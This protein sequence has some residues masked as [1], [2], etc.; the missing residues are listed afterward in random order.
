MVDDVT[1]SG[2]IE[3]VDDVTYSPEQLTF[4]IRSVAHTEVSK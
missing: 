1:Y 2:A 4:L 3:L